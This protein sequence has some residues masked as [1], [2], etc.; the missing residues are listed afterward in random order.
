MGNWISPLNESGMRRRT[1]RHV[2]SVISAVRRSTGCRRP[3]GPVCSFLCSCSYFLSAPGGARLPWRHGHSRRTTPLPTIPTALL[4]LLSSGSSLPS[5]LLL[6][7][8]LSLRLPVPFLYLTS[9]RFVVLPFVLSASSSSSRLLLLLPR[10]FRPS[11]P[12]S[13]F[14]LRAFP[15]VVPAAP[16][17]CLPPSLL[18]LSFSILLASCLSACLSVACRPRPSLPRPPPLLERPCAAK[19]R[20]GTTSARSSANCQGVA[21]TTS[22]EAS[23]SR[24]QVQ[25]RTASAPSVPDLGPIVRQHPI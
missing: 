17:V 8:S 24:S 18:L 21:T 19:M 12:F 13:F 6:P 4:F 22:D 23:S 15:F 9:S 3:T 5:T 1:C 14:R 2:P 7:P 20:P 16:F 11:S 25:A 10:P